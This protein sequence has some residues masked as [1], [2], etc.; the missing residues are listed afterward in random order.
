[1]TLYR[2]VG[3]KEMELIAQS[4][5]TSFPPRLPIQPS[6]YPVLNFEY[7][8]VEAAAQ[9][10]AQLRQLAGAENDERDHQDDDQLG[11]ADGTKHT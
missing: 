7:E 4:C 11:H 1:M 5:F 9:R 2:P 10:L 6:F 8:F 3:V